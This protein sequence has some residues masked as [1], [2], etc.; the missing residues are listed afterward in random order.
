MPVRDFSHNVIGAVG[1]VA[2]SHRLTEERLEKG[3]L[4][5]LVQE[6]GKAISAKM[7]FTLQVGKK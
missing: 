7:G 4:I 5:S 6:A 2:P 3:G 1:I